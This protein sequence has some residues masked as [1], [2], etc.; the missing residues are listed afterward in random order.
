M[1]GQERRAI[2]RFPVLVRMVNIWRLEASTV[3]WRWDCLGYF[4]VFGG[5][6]RGKR[7][8]S[9]WVFFSFFVFQEGEKGVHGR[10]LIG[11]NCFTFW[12]RL[13]LIYRKA[14]IIPTPLPSSSSL[15]CIAFN[16]K[17]LD[18]KYRR[19][20][21]TMGVSKKLGGGD[22]GYNHVLLSLLLCIQGWF[23]F[24]YNIPFPLF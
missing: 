24:E 5:S 22:R 21:S 19:F 20:Q 14:F 11:R 12:Y 16:L 8:T 18:P 2:R 6:E 1:F 4:L 7:R 9:R 13:S 23:F 15:S 10:N 3:S 17:Y